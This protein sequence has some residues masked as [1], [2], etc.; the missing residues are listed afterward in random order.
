VAINFSNQIMKA[1]FLKYPKSMLSWHC[2]YIL[3]I[4]SRSWNLGYIPTFGI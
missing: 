3:R 1:G 2:R 4:Q